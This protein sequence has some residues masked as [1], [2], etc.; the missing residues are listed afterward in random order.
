MAIKPTDFYDQL[1]SHGVEFFTGVPDSLLKE[2]CLCIDDRISNDKHIIAANE[3]NA[4]ALA[5]GYYLAQESIPLVYMQNSGLGNAVNPLLSLCDP[6]VYSIP[7][8]VMIG[9]RGEPGVKDEPQHVTQGRVQIE[10]LEALGLPYEIISK[11]DDQFYK[12]ISNVIE[13]AKNENKPVVLLIKK[14]TFEKYK[15]EI[16]QSDDQRMNREEALE[17][18]LENL[19]DNAI[20]VST[21]GKTSREIFEIREKRGQTHEQDFLTVGSM[22]HCSSIALGIALAKPHREVVCIDGDGAML[23]H[24]GSLTSIA[25]MKPKNFR[26]ILMNNEVHE[27]VGG[28]ETAAKYLDLSAIV[29]AVGSSKVFKAA[30]PNDLKTNITNFITCSGP[31]FLEV[32]IKP[33]SREDLGRPTVKPADNKE[34]FMKF[35]NK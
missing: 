12:K 9:W 20:I 5:S 3:G 28:Q 35:L 15:D 23:M 24:L 19:D 34:N 13:I 16:V 26:H 6:D 21:T 4:V 14:G 30:T 18:I 25:S 10:L 11:D 22:G 29:E 33:G 7:L 8:L 27:S 32:K 17:I 31:S 1:A 2:F